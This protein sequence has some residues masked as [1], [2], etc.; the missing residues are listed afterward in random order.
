M[1]CVMMRKTSCTLSSRSCGP[2]CRQRKKRTPFTK[3]PYN[4]SMPAGSPARMRS[5][6]WDQDG[7]DLHLVVEVLRPQLPPEEETDPLH[8]D[9]IQLLHAG[10]ISRADAFDQVGPG[11]FLWIALGLHFCLGFRVHWLPTTK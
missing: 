2:S 4:C 11:R 5:T 3:T 1:D 8:E 10:G 9:A 6:K 7:S